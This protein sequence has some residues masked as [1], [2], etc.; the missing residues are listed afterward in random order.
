LLSAGQIFSPNMQE[1]VSLVGPGE[2]H[3]LIQKMVNAGAGI[4]ALRQGE[5]GTTVHRADTGETRHI[6][7]FKTAVVDPTGA[8]NAFCGGFVAGWVKTGDICTAG[9]Y[10][11]VAASFLV[12][13]VGLPQSGLDLVE[14]AQKR[15]AVLTTKVASSQ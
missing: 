5:I 10:G 4:I 3:E 13:Q 1:A 9:L 2:P 12:E 11:A 15:L 6:P 8:G 7:A 14:T